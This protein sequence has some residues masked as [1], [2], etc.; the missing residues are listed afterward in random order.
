MS[1]RSAKSFKLV[2]FNFSLEKFQDSTPKCLG[3]SSSSISLSNKLG[4]PNSC[5]SMT[6]LRKYLAVTSRSTRKAVQDSE[7]LV[8]ENELLKS[9]VLNLED[10]NEILKKRLEEIENLLSHP[11]TERKKNLYIL[12]VKTESALGLKSKLRVLRDKL[13]E[14]EAE[15]ENHKAKMRNKKI[16]ELEEQ[17][18]KK[19]LECVRLKDQL[20]QA[21]RYG[22]TQERRIDK[23]VNVK[24]NEDELNKLKLINLDYEKALD[25]MA[26]ELYAAQSQYAML[27]KTS[28]RKSK[29]KKVTST[30][31]KKSKSELYSLQKIYDT[32]KESFDM[33]EQDI[34]KEIQEI[35]KIGDEH[36]KK[37]TNLEHQLQEKIDSIQKARKMT[38]HYKNSLSKSKTMRVTDDVPLKLHNPPMFFIEI[39]NI[40]SKKNMIIEVFLSLIDK[41]NKGMLTIDELF[42]IFSAKG[43]EI[44]RKYIENAL[45]I[46]GF[47]EK[48]VS[49]AKIEEWYMKY[50]YNDISSQ[51]PLKLSSCASESTKINDRNSNYAKKK[52]DSDKID[53][54]MYS[55]LAISKTLQCKKTKDIN[56]AQQVSQVFAEISSQ[57]Q[58]KNIPKSQIV[59]TLL[60]K[61]FNDTLPIIYEDLDRRIKKSELNLSNPLQISLLAKYLC[62]PDMISDEDPDMQVK[63]SHVKDKLIKNIQFF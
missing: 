49:L 19:V 26:R 39:H 6:S 36:Q 14:E 63:F 7:A 9:K 52:K 53:L 4:S 54:K 47:T 40:I 29:Q 58:K 24:Y 22:T 8:H 1:F 27:E 46:M 48:F 41:N 15:L 25:I 3:S 31:L 45:K 43:Q 60:G 28:K 17:M 55:K 37:L 10:E 13:F 51:S 42:T 11:S 12:Q 62:A 18:S 50:D 30:E 59:S 5:Y 38:R 61:D 23:E 33:H 56:K 35:K 16:I 21:L 2:D 34:K 44:D 57:M 32:Q 20:I